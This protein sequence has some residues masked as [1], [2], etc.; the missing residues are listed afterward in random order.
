MGLRG[1]P[2]ASC[3]SKTFFFWVG[4]LLRRGYRS[5]LQME[6]LWPLP[7]RES[8]SHLRSEFASKPSPSPSSP[9][10]AVEEKPAATLDDDVV[11]ASIS[12]R[13]FLQSIIRANG[14][15][16]LR[17]AAFSFLYMF[18]SCATPLLLKLLVQ[19]IQEGRLMDESLD[20]FAR[21]SGLL[22]VFAMAAN[23]GFGMICNQQAQHAVYRIGQ[24]VRPANFFIIYDYTSTEYSTNFITIMNEFFSFPGSRCCNRVNF[25]SRR[26]SRRARCAE[27]EQRRNGESD[28]ERRAK[29]LRSLSSNQ[30]NLDCTDSGNTPI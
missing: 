29:V 16:L 19:A 18:S 20:W 9:A 6:H 11:D 15:T 13:V 28:C 10:M 17:S 12:F 22:C 8:A 14:T 25:P 5:P 21:F 3:C 7:E 1:E 24:R 4:P 2:D 30:L 26:A 23:I 27:H